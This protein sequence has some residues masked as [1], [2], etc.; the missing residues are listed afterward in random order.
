MKHLL[1]NYEEIER[2]HRLPFYKKWF[3]DKPIKKLISGRINEYREVRRAGNTTRIANRIIEEVLTTKSAK[4]Q[5][6]FQSS[7]ANEMLLDIVLRRLDNE[8]GIYIEDMDITKI[9]NRGSFNMHTYYIL[10]IK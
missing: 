4:I 2:W 8:H 7:Q 6:H 3:T 5:D 1:E 9:V 10:T